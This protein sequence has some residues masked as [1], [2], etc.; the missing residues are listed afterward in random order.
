MV[1]PRHRKRGVTLIEL[2]CVIGIIGI[3]LALYLGPISKA[4]VHV[5][6][7]LGN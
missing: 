5:K 6:K 2:L 3:L 4:F 1:N 7:T